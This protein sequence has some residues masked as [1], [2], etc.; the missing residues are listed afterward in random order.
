[1][2]KP[3]HLS[4]TFHRSFPSRQLTATSSSANPSQAAQDLARCQSQPT[5]SKEVSKPFSAIFLL[6]QALVL[7]LI[8]SQHFPFQP[9]QA[10]QGRAKPLSQLKP[11]A[12]C[13]SHNRSRQVANPVTLYP[14]LPHFY[15][16]H[17]L[18]QTPVISFDGHSLSQLYFTAWTH[19][20]FKLSKAGL[21]PTYICKKMLKLGPYSSLHIVQQHLPMLIWNVHHPT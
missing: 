19:E 3:A 10:R 6:P 13:A 12:F 17:Q 8:I 14:I 18:Q 20:V 4:P 21:S 5:C 11:D 7:S 1:M 2:A 15:R 16:S 9:R